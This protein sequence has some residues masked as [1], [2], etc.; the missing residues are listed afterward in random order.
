[1]IDLETALGLT[2]AGALLGAG[3]YFYARRGR[4]R[5][6]RDRARMNAAR[7]QGLHIPASLHPVFD[8]NLCIG[9][10]ACVAACPEGDVIG[11]VNGVGTLLVGANCIGHGR[12]AAECPMHA[13]QLVFGT[14]E[15][16]IDIPRVTPNFE[17]TVPGIYVA[18]E[19]GGMGLIRN[20]VRQGAAAVQHIAERLRG[21]QQANADDVLIVGAGP[22]G[23][24]AALAAR[25]AGLS[26]RVIEQ[27]TFGGALAHYPRQKIV[28]TGAIELPLGGRLER[29]QI[30]KGELTEWWAR[31]RAEHGI[32]V[33]EGE[34]VEAI[35]G[36]DGAFRVMTSRSTHTARK[37]ILAIGRRGTPK[38]LGIPGE[39]LPMVTYRLI[40]PEQYAGSRVLVV[41]GGDSA[42]EAA[43]L[44]AANGA[45]TTLCYRGEVFHRCKQANRE[46]IEELE[47]AGSLRVLRSA[48]P[49]R[50]E[51]SAAV[52]DHAK[53]PGGPIPEHPDLVKTDDG[54]RR[55]TI[56]YAIICA[57][58]QL[59]TS[60]LQ[61]VGLQVDWHYGEVV[62]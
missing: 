10:L 56:D 59:P 30:T 11:I 3:G 4:A 47:H 54:S 1:L 57:G 49:I 23:F 8:P 12:C 19:L 25:R 53:E 17:S 40:E 61:H 39:D 60:L 15:R 6:E 21:Q 42:V 48:Q 62:K 26:F 27:D 2:V 13:I 24:S 44:L 33:Q 16:G 28:L 32:E 38:H 5:D 46:R 29:A 55:L 52:L 7:E 9:S 37:V 34:R 20:A 58:G 35:E 43:S 41:G 31:A 22:G 14:S 18:G 51:P 45:S 50:F 36:A